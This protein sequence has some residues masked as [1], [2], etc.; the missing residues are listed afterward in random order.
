MDITKLDE[1]IR[2][3]RDAEAVYHLAAVSDVNTAYQ[4]PVGCVEANLIGTAN[5]LEAARLNGV[6]R[7]IFASTVWVYQATSEPEPTENACFAPSG[8][9][10]IY[11]AS[12]IAGEMLCRSYQRLYAVPFTVLRYGI[13]YG[14]F[15]RRNLLI[16][17]FIRQ[18]LAGEPLVVHGDGSQFRKFI[19]VEDLARGN[20]AA[21]AS[22]A[23]N[24]TYN[25][26]G[27][28]KVTILQVAT[29][30]ERVLGEVRIRFETA[31]PGDLRGVEV[32]SGKALRDLAWEP[33]VSFEEGLER[34]VS[35]YRETFKE[36]FR[37]KM[38][39]LPI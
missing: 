2:A 32:D 27:N 3:T 1:V 18:A 22:Q 16:T 9:A 24:Q 10:H 20:V 38:T 28:E 25:L 23:A 4:D 15:M 7:V 34:T 14:P 33:T 11:T 17:T 31:R 13:P 5:V 6:K 8:V 12:K 37:A 19:Y 39:P 35:W 26:E 29:A 36:E 30:L 21:L